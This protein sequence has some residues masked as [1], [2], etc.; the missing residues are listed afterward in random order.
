MNGIGGEVVDGSG[1]IDPANLS[2][3]GTCYHFPLRFAIPCLLSRGLPVQSYFHRD[4]L[5]FAQTLRA[6]IGSHF[7]FLAIFPRLCA[8]IYTLWSLFA[9]EP[10]PFLSPTFKLIPPLV[11]G[12]PAP[13]PA[14][15][16]PRGVKR[17]RTPDHSGNGHTE[18]DQ[19]DGTCVMGGKMRRHAVFRKAIV[20][21]TIRR[22][23]CSFLRSHIIFYRCT[24]LTDVCFFPQKTKAVASVVALQRP[25]GQAPANIRLQV[26]RYK[27]RRCSRDRFL[28]SLLDH[29]RSPHLQIRPRRQR[30]WS[31]LSQ[32]SETI[33][34]TS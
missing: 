15:P 17:S 31:K 20:S 22:L 7:F 34:P 29:H 30:H 23:S 32:L 3:S 4:F 26:P 1:T 25:R 13:S 16:S 8:R 11:S 28:T 10:L 27:R 14:E 21:A 33:L 18:G 9:F 19:D 12:L 6:M 5:S 24:G 2:N